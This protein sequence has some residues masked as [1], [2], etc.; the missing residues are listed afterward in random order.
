MN[1]AWETNAAARG[2]VRLLE[3][4]AVLE[5]LDET[6]MPARDRLQH[7]LGYELAGF[8]LRALVR[9]YRRRSPEPVG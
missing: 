7:V 8:L 9:D 6:R 3:D 1:A 4:C 2:P 5:R